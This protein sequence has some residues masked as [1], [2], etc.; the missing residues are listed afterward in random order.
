MQ[1][2]L[3]AVLPNAPRATRDPRVAAV[4]RISRTNVK[5]PLALAVAGGLLRS[6]MVDNVVLDAALVEVD[7]RGRGHLS[8]G[9]TPSDSGKSGH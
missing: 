6:H 3:C 1:V 2:L 7:G 8:D 5:D 4:E 9:Y